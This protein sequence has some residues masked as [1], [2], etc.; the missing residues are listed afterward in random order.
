M[1]FSAHMCRPQLR[2]HR[3]PSLLFQPPSTLLGVFPKGG[4]KSLF[5]P[6]SGRLTGPLLLQVL[7][8][9]SGAGRSRDL[10]TFDTISSSV[11]HAIASVPAVAHT[12]GAFRPASCHTGAARL[13][14]RPQQIQKVGAEGWGRER[15]H[16]AYSRL[17][18]G[19]GCFAAETITENMLHKI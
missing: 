16:D 13:C 4:L 14:P 3:L 18:P 11:R 15:I 7:E 10:T 17:M 2:Y 19:T 8:Q 1:H 12:L 6:Q 5:R 9:D